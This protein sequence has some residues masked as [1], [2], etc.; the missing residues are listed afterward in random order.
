MLTALPM[1][2][3]GLVL[4]LL[5]DRHAPTHQLGNYIISTRSEERPFGPGILFEHTLDSIGLDSLVIFNTSVCSAPRGHNT[6]L[7]SRGLQSRKTV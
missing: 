3:L 1:F 4:I 2:T 6:R 5:I 7:I